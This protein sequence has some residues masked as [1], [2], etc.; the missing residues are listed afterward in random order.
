MYLCRYRDSLGIFTRVVAWVSSVRAMTLFR[1][2][3]LVLFSTRHSVFHISPCPCKRL[4]ACLVF[5]VYEIA[6]L[7]HLCIYPVEYAPSHTLS[8]VIHV[9]SVKCSCESLVY[10]SRYCLCQTLL[11][12]LELILGN[13]NR[14]RYPSDRYAP[15]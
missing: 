3:D 5:Y 4:Q 11:F 9:T 12:Y 6:C 2:P 8:A 1:S 13:C 14:S 10:L 15:S 7:R